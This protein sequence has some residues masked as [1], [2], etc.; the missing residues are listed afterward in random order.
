MRHKF[1]KLQPFERLDHLAYLSGIERNEIGIAVHEADP[2]WCRERPELLTA[3]SDMG[4]LQ[5]VRRSA[6]SP[7][8]NRRPSVQALSFR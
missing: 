5:D 8:V 1:G 4:S 2:A 6:G 3:V 7:V